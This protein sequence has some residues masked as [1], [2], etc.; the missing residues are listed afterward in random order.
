MSTADRQ[1]ADKIAHKMQLIDQE[2]EAAVTLFKQGRKTDA[3]RLYVACGEGLVRIQGETRD[4]PMFVEA[5]KAR[6]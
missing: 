6:V 4:D 5:L 2:M 3:A 1:K